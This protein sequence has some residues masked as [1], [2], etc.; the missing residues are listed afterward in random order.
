RNRALIDAHGCLTVWLDAPFELCW[1]RTVSDGETRPLARTRASAA[2]LY[3]ERRA[4][5]ALAAL[6]VAAED[7]TSPADL[8]ASIETL[9]L[10][11]VEG[12]RR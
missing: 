11:Q 6:R 3:E 1:Q 8:A 7:A 5:Y 4:L 12:E 9:M 10:N 2:R